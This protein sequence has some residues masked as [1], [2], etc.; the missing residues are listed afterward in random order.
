MEQNFDQ[1]TLSGFTL[2]KSK[3]AIQ[4]PQITTDG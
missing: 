3:E 2:R 4:V 1:D